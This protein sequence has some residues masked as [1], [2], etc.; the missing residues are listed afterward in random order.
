M[1]ESKNYYT[2]IPS[3]VRYDKRLKPLSK[4]IYG[5]ITALTNDKGYCWANNNYF[6]EIYSVSKDTISRAIRQLEEY[7]Y[8][9]CVY[10]KSKQNNEKR[11][12][13][14]KNLYHQKSLY[15]IVKILQT[16]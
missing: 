13:Y 10:D 16:V 4:L 7:D 1:K 11:K 15:G 8:I 5:E 12:I 3:A 6:A 14:I 9:K 2:I